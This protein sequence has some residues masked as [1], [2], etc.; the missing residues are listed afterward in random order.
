MSTP[1]PGPAGP[2]PPVAATAVAL[3]ALI[4]SARR[5]AERGELVSVDTWD[6]IDT[7]NDAMIAQLPQ[8]MPRH[9]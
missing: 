3:K 7:L 8:P 4:G 9:V 1:A 5:Q 2:L 6:A